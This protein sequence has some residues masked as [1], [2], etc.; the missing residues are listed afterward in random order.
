MPVRDDDYSQES[1]DIPGQALSADVLTTCSDFIGTALLN[2]HGRHERG[3][4]V[5]VCCGDARGCSSN[6]LGG[7]VATAFLAARAGHSLREGASVSRDEDGSDGSGGGSRNRAVAVERA[8]V[9]VRNARFMAFQG[10]PA[11]AVLGAL[12]DFE[13][14]LTGGGPTTSVERLRS[15]ILEMEEDTGDMDG[16]PDRG[17]G[18]GSGGGGGGGDGGGGPFTRGRS[19]SNGDSKDSD[20]KEQDGDDGSSRAFRLDRRSTSRQSSSGS[21]GGEEKLPSMTA[22]SSS[23]KS[24]M[25]YVFRSS[26]SRRKVSETLNATKQQAQLRQSAGCCSPCNGTVLPEVA[27]K[28]FRAME[29]KAGLAEDDE[30]PDDVR[31]HKNKIAEE[32]LTLHCPECGMAFIDFTNCFALWCGLCDCAFCAY[33]QKSCRRERNDAHNHVERCDFNIAPGK[34]IFASR[35]VFEHS[36]NLR[37]VRAVAEYLDALPNDGGGTPEAVEDISTVEASRVTASDEEANVT[38]EKRRQQPMRALVA[39]AI[40][41]DLADLGIAIAVD[42]DSGEVALEVK[43]RLPTGRGA[44]Y[45]SGVGGYGGG[46][47]GV[48][49]W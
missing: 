3:P 13:S 25:T 44:S 45:W 7:I 36:Q 1:R 39:D 10:E 12:V 42:A 18:G 19:G 2:A 26:S 4:V 47:S 48:R 5:L 34:S 20:G 30:M 17:G 29:E 16:G 28:N 11:D 37:R 9:A 14:R 46:R 22:G 23:L 6:C 32:L 33:C 21:S 41:K 38:L 24:C 49:R 31:R 35:K 27:A 8:M 43:T 15:I 40:Q